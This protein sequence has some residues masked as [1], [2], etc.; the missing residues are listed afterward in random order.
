MKSS[1][2]NQA[3]RLPRR[4]ALTVG[5]L[6]ASALATTSVLLPSP[7]LAQT[8]P[9]PTAGKVASANPA[10]QTPH[11]KDGEA[12]AFAQIGSTV[13]VGG[14][15]TQA[16]RST[17][18]SFAAHRYLFAYNASTGALSSTFVPQL[19]GAV[20]ALA[21][22]PN[23]K[24]IVGGAFKNV[25][26]VSRKNLVALDPST[27]QTVSTWSGKS[28]GGTVRSLV[29][30][31]NDLYVGGS[32]HWMNGAAHSLL[33]R[34]NATSGA[35]D[36]SFQIDASVPRSSTEYVWTLAVAPNGSTLVAGGNFTQVNGQAR[37]QVVMVDLTGTP[38]VADWNTQRFGPA[39]YPSFISYV[40][41]ID[42][43]DDSSYFVISANGGR[44][45]GTD[46]DSVSRWETAERGSA[47]DHT[48]VD[49]TGTDS[50][51]SIE[52]ADGVIYAAGHFRWL[53]NANGNDAASDGAVD[54][55]GIG[56]IAGSNGLPLNWNPRRS[57]GS[58]LPAGATAWDSDV[59]VLWR[60]TDG[61][62]FGQ[63]SD[64]M[65]NEYHGRLGMFPLA[66]ARNVITD[67]APTG[68]SGF[69][70][71][72]G[73]N[74]QLTKVAYNNGTVGA[75]ST[76]SQPN[77]TSAGAAWVIGGKLYWGRSGVTNQLQFSSFNGTVGAPWT[78]GYDTWFKASTLT[79]GFYLNG[80]LYYTRTG[81]NQLYYR[82]LEPDSY[83]VG[84][85]EFTLPTSNLSWNAVR[86]MTYVNGRIVYGS[87][88][89][90]LRSV[91]FDPTAAPGAVVDGSTA[92]TLAAPA[93]G[94]SWSRSTLFFA[95][96]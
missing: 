67:N 27:G 50:V 33:A 86:G 48:W 87:T 83:V 80:R 28:D 1:P 63:N 25:N 49:Y 36:P 93:A 56:A 29:V 30:H 5:A 9:A 14:T 92:S 4:R 58:H 88:D 73:T 41:D 81:T 37:N 11:A 64:G 42:F 18:T 78:N 19:D 35:I 76:T 84:C 69:L 94:V 66:G 75:H 71:L 59:A 39:C 12:R 8:V 2:L 21:V 57:A 24:L 17:G 22:S 34:L 65:G 53:N 32:F 55:L 72:G 51:T 43:S 74:G 61:L 15:F 54:R 13:Y 96:R 44:G 79:G 38:A 46:C 85:T 68:S 89:G 82:Y 31:G 77:L 3:D 23:G 70:Y 47:V 95:T 10:D 7:A 60:G 40:T 45:T 26:G 6:A 62:Y 90:S 91:A 52:A 16:K 20:N